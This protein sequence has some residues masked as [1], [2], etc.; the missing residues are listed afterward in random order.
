MSKK[1]EAEVS[2]ESERVIAQIAG[3]SG[4]GK[5]LWV[6]N[7][8]NALIY[9]TDIGG[10]QAPYKKRILDNGSEVVTTATSFPEILKDLRERARDGRLDKTK[11]VAIDHVTGLQQEGVLRHNPSLSADYGRSGDATT[12]EWRQ[13]REFIRHLDFNLIVTAHLKGRW[14]N[15]KQVGMITD[16]PKN[17]EADVGIVLYLQR[18][19]SYP[20]MA[21]VQKWRRDPDDP[22]GAVPANFIFTME[23]FEKIAGAGMGKPRA[24]VALASA[25]QIKT[26]NDLLAVVKLPDGETDKWLTKA[27]VESFE[28]MPA[29]KLDKCIMA[30]N[31]KLPKGANA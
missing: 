24:P 9:D 23:N 3:E 27:G 10:G 26:I 11:T 25:E 5:S 17:I 19:A 20:G 15:D 7:L 29:D 28:D 13:I 4:A 12:R 18:G 14:A 1:V 6:A 31:A 30:L 16:G 22:R 8:K 21:L 2:W